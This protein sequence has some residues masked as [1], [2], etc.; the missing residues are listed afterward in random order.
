MFVFYVDRDRPLWVD[1]RSFLDAAK[2]IYDPTQPST[3]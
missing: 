2:E 1:P 3:T